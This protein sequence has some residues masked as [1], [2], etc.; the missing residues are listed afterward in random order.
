[1]TRLRR[2]LACAVAAAAMAAPAAHAAVRGPHHAR[3]AT[4]GDA[5]SQPA[6]GTDA[7]QASFC[8]YTHAAS[9]NAPARKYW[10]YRPA[11]AATLPGDPAP[12]PRS[13]VVFLHGCN[14]T[15]LDA[16][17]ATHFNTLADK[18]SGPNHDQPTFDVV[19]P[20]Q[21]NSA[22]SSAPL[23]DGNGVGCWNWFLT[24]DQSRGSGEPAAITGIT[25]SVAGYAGFG[26]DR[27]RVYVEGISAG[28][29]MAVI[30][31]A[32]YP[33]V[34]AAVGVLAGCAYRT[35]G[36]VTGVLSYQAMGAHAR[37]VPMFIEN[38]T[39]DS[40]NN[41]AMAGTI[42][43]SWLGV[44]DMVDD[45][46]MNGS[47]SRQPVSTQSYDTDQTPSPGSGDACIHNNTFTCPGGVIGFQ[48]SYPY[49]VAQYADARGCDVLEFWVI[50]GME[51]AHPDA[52]GDG[53]YTDPLGPDVTAA[54]YDFFNNYSLSS[55][56]KTPSSSAEVSS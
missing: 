34:Y 27:S 5:P 18:L 54:S 14:E 39:A 7:T 36:D 50:H 4:F 56:C 3:I 16:A 32:T 6:C 1:V 22:P 37:V 51:H 24:D 55:G 8:E 35:C 2:G 40:L 11:Q 45:G 15:A 29:D 25:Q 12:A 13:L 20:E 44:D 48:G 26:I 46:S 10:L 53:P 28:A 49:T 31:G 19:Y 41:M 30:L 38:G 17:Q 42:V 52:P 21:V 43:S 47:M 33:D 23:A 9:T